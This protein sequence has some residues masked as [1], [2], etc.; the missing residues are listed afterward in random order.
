MVGVDVD[1]ASANHTAHRRRSNAS[2][3]AA[4]ICTSGRLSRSSPGSQR[5][6]A[7]STETLTVHGSPLTLSTLHGPGVCLGPVGSRRRRDLVLGHEQRGTT[8]QVPDAVGGVKPNGARHVGTTC[9]T[10]RRLRS[11]AHL[12]ALRDRVRFAH[13]RRAR[14]HAG[15]VSSSPRLSPPQCLGDTIFSNSTHSLTPRSM[16]ALRFGHHIQAQPVCSAAR[17]RDPPAIDTP[18]SLARPAQV[19]RPLRLTS[20][21]VAKRP[22]L[23]PDACLSGSR[24]RHHRHCPSPRHLRASTQAYPRWRDALPA[25]A[26]CVGQVRGISY[27]AKTDVL[28]PVPRVPTTCTTR[29]GNFGI[30]PQ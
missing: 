26:E 20:A 7:W 4:P 9:N 29:R 2:N 21:G 23:D 5:V 15:P 13:E 28:A 14:V 17:H 30:H 18:R 1:F 11:S 16:V 8:R 12:R 25:A 22:R 3:V 19:R 6:M 24:A 10:R 27:H